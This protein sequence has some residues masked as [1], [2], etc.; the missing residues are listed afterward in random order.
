[1]KRILAA[2]LAL[3][4]LWGCGRDKSRPPVPAQE[5]ADVKR[6]AEEW[7]NEASIVLLRDY[8]QIDTTPAR[9]EQEGAE[10]LARFFDCEGI[11]AEVVCPAPGRCY[12]VTP[13]P[14]R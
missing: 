4:L 13:L 14:G 1:M 6:P 12:V 10:F 2:A 11:E 3:P 9:G 5:L 8:V 7:L